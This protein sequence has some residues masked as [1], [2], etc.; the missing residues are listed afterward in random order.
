MDSLI[1]TFHIDYRLLIAQIINFAIVI[2]VLYFFAVK[3][4]T[5]VMQ[6]RTKKIE[7]SLDD[8]KKID[9]RML[10]AE[11]EFK[12][13]VAQAKIDAGS[14]MEKAQVHAEEKRKE[15]LI[16]TKEEIGQIINDEKAMI[17]QEKAKI[18]KEIKADISD[19]VI[20]SVEKIL[21]KKMDKKEDAELIKSIIKK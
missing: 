5:K 6:D 21:E 1:E 13:T 8:A 19:L 2:S 3:P 14:I 20:S 7:K 10:E 16:K 18:L 9:I 15:M 11:E 17:Q 4:L 12:K